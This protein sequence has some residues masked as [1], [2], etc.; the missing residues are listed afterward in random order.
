MIG[1]EALLAGTMMRK[2]GVCRMG[3][4]RKS[5]LEGVLSWLIRC[6]VPNREWDVLFLRRVY[7]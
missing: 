5:V 3:W 7:F 1:R 6:Y 2:R 4:V